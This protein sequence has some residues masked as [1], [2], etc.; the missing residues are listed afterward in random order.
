MNYFE[1]QRGH[2]LCNLLFKLLRDAN[3]LLE[4]NQCQEQGGASFDPT[5]C[6]HSNHSLFLFI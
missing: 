1:S 2:D 4:Q 6:V 3:D 5:F